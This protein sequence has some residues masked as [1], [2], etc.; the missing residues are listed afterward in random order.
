MHCCCK[1][2]SLLVDSQGISGHWKPK[3][4]IN[5]PSWPRGGYK[6]YSLS[7]HVGLALRSLTVWQEKSIRRPC[8]PP[9]LDWPRGLALL[10]L[11]AG[12]A[13]PYLSLLSIITLLGGCAASGRSWA[14]RNQ[15]LSSASGCPE[16]ASWHSL[17]TECLGDM[18]N[19]RRSWR[20]L[21]SAKQFIWPLLVQDIS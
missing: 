10:F 18:C 7:L 8:L 11:F 9:A 13:Q 2:V 12:K 14:A 19:H 3:D 17:P 21:R 6:T 16:K 20:S 5:D 4:T 15:D 1:C